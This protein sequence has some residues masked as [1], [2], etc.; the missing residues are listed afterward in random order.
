MDYKNGLAREE[1][2]QHMFEE[3]PS[4]FNNTF[5]RE[6]LENIVDY[7]LSGNLPSS[8]NSLYYFLKDMI[9][10]IEQKDLLPYM[11]SNMLTNEVLGQSTADGIEDSLIKPIH[12]MDDLR[13]YLESDG[14]W[15]E[16]CGIGMDGHPGW[17]IGKHSPAGEDFWF[18]FEHN[19]NVQTAVEQIL[20]YA[21][22]F[23]INEHVE[24]WVGARGFVSGIPDVETLVEDAKAIKDMLMDMATNVNHASKLPYDYSTANFLD[25]EEK[26]RDFVELSKAEFLASYSYLTEAEYDN[27]MFLWREQQAEKPSL[28]NQISGAATKKDAD[29][30]VGHQNNKDYSI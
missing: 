5:S 28:D 16:E 3:F 12:S 6:M 19:N 20:E 4:V 23:D 25:D 24:E 21:Y 22:C 7:G 13:D 26:M 1:F 30:P 17:E 11:D 2:L 9:P 18:S 27:T 29:A 10:E 8:K 15:I 14:W